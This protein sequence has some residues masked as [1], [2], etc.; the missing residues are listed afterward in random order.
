MKGIGPKAVRRNFCIEIS[1]YTSTAQCNGSPIK[2]L[3]STP[4]VC[5]LV[6]CW[7]TSA[8]SL[9]I[10]QFWQMPQVET[11]LFW[12]TCDFAKESYWRCHNAWKVTTVVYRVRQK[13]HLAQ[14]PLAGTANMIYLQKISRKKGNKASLLDIPSRNSSLQQVWL[15]LLSQRLHLNNYFK[16]PFIFCKFVYV[17]VLHYISWQ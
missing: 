5:Q 1:S 8:T 15:D 16:K 2:L 9:L 10:L 12:S 17:F 14:C 7:S 13:A 4:S 6:L 11:R 3:S